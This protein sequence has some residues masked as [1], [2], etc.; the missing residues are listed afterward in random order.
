MNDY[1]GYV[2]PKFDRLPRKVRAGYDRPTEPF[3]NGGDTGDADMDMVVAW[4]EVADGIDEVLDDV[5]E[6]IDTQATQVMRIPVDP[7]TN[8]DVANGVK[9]LSG[10]DH[11][12]Y[13]DGNDWN[14]ALGIRNSSSMLNTAYE[15]DLT[16]MLWAEVK[17]RIAD[18]L[19]NIVDNIPVIGDDMADA[20][21]EDVER[22]RSKS[23]QAALGKNELGTPLK[24]GE[25]IGS[26]GIASVDSVL[27]YTGGYISTPQPL[28]FNPAALQLKS[29]INGIDTSWNATRSII[30]SSYGIRITEEVPHRKGNLKHQVT[31]EGKDAILPLTNAYSSIRNNIITPDFWKYGVA[32]TDGFLRGVRNTLRGYIVGRDIACCLLDNILGVSNIVGDNLK[33][34]RMLRLGLM[35]SFNGLNI[36]VDS[37]YNVLADILNQAIMAAMGKLITTLQ[38]VLDN[39]LMGGRNYFKDF[40]ARKGEAWR[41][42]WPFDELMEFSMTSLGRMESD[43]MAYINDYTN[44]MKVVHINL[45]KYVIQLKDREYSRRMLILADLLVQGVES[46]QLCKELGDLEVEYAKP[47]PEELARFARDYTYRSSINVHAARTKFNRAP[48]TGTPILSDQE[49]TD[50]DRKWLQN[51][52]TSLTNNELNELAYGLR[53]VRL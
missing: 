35:Y 39:W 43:L 49:L 10:G 18:W 36:R 26:G 9:L 21:M 44:M 48:D 50:N 52:D 6:L 38:T 15:Y 1:I 23:A 37:L 20:L 14:R 41:R 17:I 5:N 7:T 16:E 46:G 30:S 32:R 53:G 47:S 19:A 3:M 28:N 12:N 25:L 11:D 45:N 31:S 27:G 4:A 40:A 34:L 33:F 2:P 29:I 24:M 42:C 22:A 51:C 13:I 8:P